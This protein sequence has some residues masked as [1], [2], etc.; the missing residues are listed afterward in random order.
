VHKASTKGQDLAGATFSI[1]GQSVTTDASGNACV[2]HLAFGSYDVKETGAPAGYAINDSSTHSVA[3]NVNQDCSAATV[4]LDLQFKDTPLTD[5]H[6][7]AD[8][9][10]VGGTNSQ[11]TCVDS[12]NIGIGD[13]PSGNV[14]HAKVTAL[15]LNPGTYTCTVVIDP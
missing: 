7:T 11:I 5:V 9:Q 1:A 12:S 3:V 4:P 2:D 14:E 15:G 13:S 10:A 8:S 6:V